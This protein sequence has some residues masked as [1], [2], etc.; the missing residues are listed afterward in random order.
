MRNYLC[1]TL[2]E[3]LLRNIQRIGIYAGSFDPVH[4]GHVAFALQA[5]K[6]AKLDQ[7]IFMPER[8]PRHKPSVE[9]YAHR[10]AMLKRA[11]TPHPDLAV[12]EMVDR[13]FSVSR[14]LPQLNGLFPDSTLVF[15]MGSD[16]AFSVPHWPFVYRMLQTSELLVGVR[17]E[18]ETN[19]VWDAVLSWQTSPQGLTVIDSYAGDVSSRDVRRA[20]QTNRS[21]KGVLCSVRRYARQEWLYVSPG[22]SIA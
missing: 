22:S 3:S 16:T 20:L 18:H 12:M 2:K 21:T 1:S 14:T 11:L 10:V 19:Q 9:H 4:A 5:L 7:I 17:S 13:N 15:M 6:A 8:L